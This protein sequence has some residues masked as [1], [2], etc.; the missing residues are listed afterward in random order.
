MIYMFLYPPT[1]EIMF[2][3]DR[4]WINNAVRLSVRVCVCVCVCPTLIGG[5]LWT[6]Q[7]G[8]AKLGVLWAELGSND[9]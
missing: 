5:R 7:H 2:S 6:A 4:Y 1:G 8:I 3:L 9:S